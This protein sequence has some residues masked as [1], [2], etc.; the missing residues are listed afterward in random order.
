M[1]IKFSDIEVEYV[2]HMGDDLRVVNAARVSFN[3]WKNEFDRQDAKLI[4]YLAANGHWSPFAHP[5]LTVV[6]K[7]P[8]FLARQLAKHQVGFAWNEVSR[9]YVDFEPEFYDCPLRERPQGGIKQGSG[10][11]EISYMVD[12]YHSALETSLIAYKTLLRENVAPECARSVLPLTAMTE[13]M[14]TGSLYGWSRV[15]MLRKD[16]HAQQEA[17]VFAKFIEELLRDHFP[18]SC[19][20]LLEEKELD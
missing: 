9:R 13:W 14:W 3:K 12:P 7:A 15:V 16:K 20:H 8:I 6:C 2:D 10:A 19:L 1:N 4:K 11:S 17:Q 5:Q 18:I